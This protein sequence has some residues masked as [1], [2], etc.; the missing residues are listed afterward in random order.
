MTTAILLAAGRGSRLGPFTE[1]RPK[2]LVKCAGR[3]MIESQIEALRGGGVERIV[4]VT[5]YCADL[6]EEYGHRRVANPDWAQT[7][8]VRSLFCA[9]EEVTG[10]TVVSYSDIVYGPEPV[11]ALLASPHAFA[12]TYDVDWLE[13]WRRRFDDP[14][15]DAESFR[16]SGDGRIVD[17]GRKHVSLAE[18]GGQYMGLLKIG[19]EVLGWI[20]RVAR[21]RD[22]SRMDMTSLIAHLIAADEP[23]YGVPV[24]GGWAEID[25]PRDLKV[26]EE[27][28]GEGR[29]RS[30]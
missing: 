23:V 19:P 16:L 21:H 20:E 17:I 13:L 12:L 18:I 8:M 2:C 28:V 15:S 3:P 1:E 7:N 26:A 22:L 9:A 27:L 11:R 29:I 30:R 25:S 4:V 10:P 5:G 24:H 6:L 14:L